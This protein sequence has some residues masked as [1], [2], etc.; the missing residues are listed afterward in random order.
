MEL[1]PADSGAAEEVNIALQGASRLLM[2]TT[3]PQDLCLCHGICSTADFVLSAGVQL[4]RQDVAIFADQVGDFIIEQYLNAEQ[5]LPCVV[6]QRGVAR[7][8]MMG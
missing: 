6:Q 1:L 5:P 2:T 7:G 4:N 3:A 8:L